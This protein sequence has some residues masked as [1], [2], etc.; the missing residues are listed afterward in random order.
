M[1]H[2]KAGA[3]HA[4]Q[5]DFPTVHG[6]TWRTAF[7]LPLACLRSANAFVA[8][9]S[10]SLQTISR[11]CNLSLSLSLS[12]AFTPDVIPVYTS[13]PGQEKMTLKI[14]QEHFPRGV[15]FTAQN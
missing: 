6:H 2:R 10:L 15:Y 8:I 13:V 4:R 14:E 11:K 12:D 9:D 7:S 3:T 1:R 5:S